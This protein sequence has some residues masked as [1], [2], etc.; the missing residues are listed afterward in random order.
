MSYGWDFLMFSSNGSKCM[1]LWKHFIFCSLSVQSVNPRLH[2]S[3]IFGAFLA[4]KSILQTTFGFLSFSIRDNA[5]FSAQLF[6]QV[7]NRNSS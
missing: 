1:H 5:V 7:Y 2:E 6:E 4:V 3:V